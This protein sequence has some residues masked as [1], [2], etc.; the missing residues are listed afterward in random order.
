VPGA[1]GGDGLLSPDA[2]LVAHSRRRLPAAWPHAHRATAHVSV[3]RTCELGMTRATGHPYRHLLEVLEEVT[4]PIF[5]S[6]I[7]NGET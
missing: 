1:V 7:A 6:D 5:P 2:A 4:R 3:N